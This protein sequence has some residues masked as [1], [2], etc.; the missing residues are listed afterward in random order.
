MRSVKR[1]TASLKSPERLHPLR[2]AHHSFREE[3]ALRIKLEPRPRDPLL[4]DYELPLRGSYYPLG[5]PLEIR[6]NSPD[7]LEAA[8][9]SWGKFHKSFSTPPVRIRLGVLPGSSSL[10]PAAPSC[11]GQQNL[12]TQVADGE[13][14][15]VSDIRE[16]FAFGWVSEAAARKH[17]YLRNFMEGPA[18]VML[19]CLY[20]TPV[21]AA[22]ISLDS[23]GVLLCGDGGAGKSSLS[24]ACARSGWTFLSDDASMLVRK[25]PGRL[26]IG[27]P[28]RMRFRDS[29]RELFP[30]LRSERVSVRLS[31]ELAIEL[32]TASV[33][34]ITT[35]SVCTVDYL[36]FLNRYNPE[37]EGLFRFPRERALSWLNQVVRYGEQPLRAEHKAVLRRLAAV[38]MFEM[39]YTKMDTALR[40]LEGLVRDRPGAADAALAAAGEY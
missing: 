30:E 37:P 20:L 14:Y 6:T 9:E 5:F 26:V 10:C 1:K 18:L 2:P 21:H 16:G 39:R 11:R 17:I 28:Y 23:C 19:E 8:E 29:A 33:P 22:C 15:L 35:A 13:N 27:N 32:A 7:V 4:W 25:S 31:G 38:E 12:I 24:Y 3:R 36:V 34:G 40:L